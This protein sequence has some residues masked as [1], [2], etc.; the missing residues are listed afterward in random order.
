MAWWITES[1]I[2]TAADEIVARLS[3]HSSASCAPRCWLAEHRSPMA[4]SFGEVDCASDWKPINEVRL[5][6]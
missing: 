5:T 2:H 6:A 4:R 1:D 3:A